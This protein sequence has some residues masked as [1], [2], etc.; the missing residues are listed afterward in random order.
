ML[1]GS[2]SLV[3]TNEQMNFFDE[4]AKQAFIEIINTIKPND[5]TLTSPD[6]Y[7]HHL[8]TD[9]G[10]VIKDRAGVYVIM[11]VQTGECI[12]GQTR[13]FRKRFN[14]Y[15]SRGKAILSDKIRINKNFFLAVQ[16]ELKKG[17]EY[18]QFIQRFVVYSWVDNN[19]KAL[20][21]RNS[22]SLQNEMS[23][24]E[25]RLILA[26]HACNLCYNIQDVSVKF[27]EFPNIDNYDVETKEELILQKSSDELQSF[28]SQGKGP[29][30]AKPFQVNGFY[31]LTTN[32]YGIFRKSL[33]SN[34]KKEFLS[35]PHLRRILQANKE[36]FNSTTRSLTLDEIQ[37]AWEKNLFIRSK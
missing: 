10:K 25:H 12:I 21:V 2:F 22:L 23:Y 4:I 35:M 19:K 30:Q 37:T 33:E 7:S 20:D 6:L 26:F 17:F 16:K 13:N 27:A 5:I 36:N 9:K 34:K 11:N 3:L 31:F 14:Q 32:D 1:R 28:I 15:T 24:L 18:S 29:N 8:T